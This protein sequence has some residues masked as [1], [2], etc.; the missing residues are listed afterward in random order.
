ML[1]KVNAVVI[2]DDDERMNGKRGGRDH[3]GVWKMMLERA[4]PTRTVEPKYLERAC[5]TGIKR[6]NDMIFT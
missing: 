6:N 3:D 4:F 2:V 5:P 1:V